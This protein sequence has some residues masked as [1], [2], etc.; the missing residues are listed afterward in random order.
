MIAGK[1]RDG[2]NFRRARFAGTSKMMYLGCQWRQ[3]VKVRNEEET[4]SK[5][6]VVT[7]HTKVVFQTL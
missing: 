7:L 3:N 2:R 1:K 4:E 5:I 6:I